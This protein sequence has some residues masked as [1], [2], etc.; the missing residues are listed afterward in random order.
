MRVFRT[1]STRGLIA[2]LATVGVVAIAATVAI[3]A[4]GSGGPTPQPTSLANAIHDALTAP[5]PEGVTA[6]VHFTNN[7]LPSGALAGQAGSALLTGADGRLWVD[8][9]GGRIEL[10]SDSGDT[11]ITWNDSK[12][13][14]YDSSANTAYVVDLPAKTTSGEPPGTPPTLDEIT[15]ALQEAAVHWAISDA[16]PANVGGAEA[17][18]VT[19]SPRSADGLLGSAELA[20]DALQGTPLKFAVYARGSSTPALALEVTSISFGS[21]PAGDLTISPPAGTKVVD[22]SSQA[23]GGSGTEPQPV[24]GLAA[25]Q[26]AAPF[27]IVAPDTLG[28]LQREDVRLVGPADSRSVIVVFGRGLGALVVIERKADTSASGSGP[29][30]S[31][32]AVSLGG[33]P[34]HELATPL[35]TVVTWDRGGVSFVLAGSVANTAAEAAARELG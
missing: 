15:K 4:S 29:T 18:T 16:T 13:T 28:G 24:T 25:V 19:V 35:G 9:T 5:P 3:G 21:V 31:L 27:A 17:Y 11:Q 2:G 20:W 12:L 23:A 10:Q 34:A 6:R 14:V 30:G 26:A 8:R 1:A 32:P 33:G 22:L 7:L